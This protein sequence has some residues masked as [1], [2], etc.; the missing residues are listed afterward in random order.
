MTVV[1]DADRVPD[2]KVLLEHRRVQ[3][4]E[5]KE[6]D[7]LQQTVGFPRATR[8]AGLSPKSIE[9]DLIALGVSA[10]YMQ[11]EGV[12]TNIKLMYNNSAY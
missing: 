8:T 10:T 2:P 4:Q 6:L 9:E 1:L 11:W 3:F 5:S 12:D 7:H